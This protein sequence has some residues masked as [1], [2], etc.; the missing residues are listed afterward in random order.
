[1]ST[2]AG[3]PVIRGETTIPPSGGWFGTYLLNSSTLPALGPTAL[4]IHD[5]VLVGRIIRRDFADHPGGALVTATVQGG[6]GWR[7]PVTRAGTYASSG[8]VRLSTVLRDLAAMADESYTAPAEVT[9]GTAYTWQAHTP[10]SPVHG[11]DILADLVWRR[12]VATWRVEPFTGL[13]RFDAWPSL[14]RADGRGRI[15]ARDLA[16]GRRT[17]GLDVAVR[18]CLPGATIEDALITRTVLQETASD[19]RAHVY[20]LSAGASSVVGASA[21]TATQRAAETPRGAATVRA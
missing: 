7:L 3:L 15:V 16:R 4:V 9:L 10:T 2:L 14:G 13:T 1:M 5:L 6:A 17:I 21:S 19:L 11:A 12:F 18:A 20:S 8:G